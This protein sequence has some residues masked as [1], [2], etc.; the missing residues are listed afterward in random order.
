V[1]IFLAD[2]HAVLRAG[3]RSLL[4]ADADLEVVGEAADGLTTLRKAEELRPDLVLMDISM[5]DMGGIEATQRLTKICPQV[6][7][8]IMTA[9]D[10]EGL[11][12]GAIR[13][14]ASGYLL[15][16][17]AESEVIQAIRVVMRGDV[18]IHPSM[19]R[20]LVKELT[21]L[22]GRS[23]ASPEQLTPRE[24]EVLRLLARGYTNRQIAEILNI[25]IR[26][27]EGHRA[28]LAGKLGLS[29]RV[30]LA[31]YAEEHHLLE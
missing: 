16:R 17:A 10:D 27:V 23:P 25:S 5:P 20:L 1:R 15:K 11:L 24:V 26:T 29:S 7:V 13:A 21:T 22:P 28:N 8:L 2:D 19:T 12:H 4:T 6:K 31:N 3:L 14:G 30:E 18:Y 9:Y